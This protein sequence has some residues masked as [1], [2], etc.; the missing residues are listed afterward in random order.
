MRPR[1]RL[2]GVTLDAVEAVAALFQ[3]DAVRQPFDLPNDD[4][5]VWEITYRAEN[6]NIR[7]LLWPAIDRIDITVGP[8]MWVVKGIREVEVIEALEFL[9][10]FG[11]DGVVSVALNGQIIL[12]TTNP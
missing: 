6:G 7:I 9:A 11:Q 1:Q 12:T 2:T 5:G 10:R 8:H 4:L 3:A